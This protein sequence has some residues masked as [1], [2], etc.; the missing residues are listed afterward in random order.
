MMFTHSKCISF[1]V[2]YCSYRSNRSLQKQ[3]IV[4]TALQAKKKET[5]LALCLIHRILGEKKHFYTAHDCRQ[6][7]L[8]DSVLMHILMYFHIL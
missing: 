4:I 1:S 5:L 8:P 2:K 3:L 7:F 6:V